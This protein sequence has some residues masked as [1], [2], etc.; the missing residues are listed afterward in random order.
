MGVAVKP[1][2]NCQSVFAG[3]FHGQP[4]HAPPAAAELI[5]VLQ[6]ELEA[7]GLRHSQDLDTMA[8][9]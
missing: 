2:P 8:G 4:I 9:R 3:T 7:M 1:C 6:R 5:R